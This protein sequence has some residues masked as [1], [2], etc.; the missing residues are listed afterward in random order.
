MPSA[1]TDSGAAPAAAASTT[2][3]VSHREELLREASATG[4]E[5]LFQ[6]WLEP[7]TDLGTAGADACL[8]VRVADPAKSPG[9]ADGGASD[10]LTITETESGKEHSTAYSVHDAWLPLHCV[11]RGARVVLAAA[12]PVEVVVVGSAKFR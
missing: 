10:A 6:G 11:R 1:T 8:R 12:M 3:R 2:P 5:V 7:S 9:P 4:L